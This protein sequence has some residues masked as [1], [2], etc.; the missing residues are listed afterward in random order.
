[1]LYLDLMTNVFNL[2]TDTVNKPYFLSLV[3]LTLM[4]Y[5]HDEEHFWQYSACLLF[6]IYNLVVI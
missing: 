5:E 6:K 3:G 4:Q 1:L 2:L